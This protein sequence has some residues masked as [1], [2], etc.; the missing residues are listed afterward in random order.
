MELVTVTHEIHTFQTIDRPC[1]KLLECDF[2]SWRDCVEIESVIVILLL[3]F[4]IGKLS[5]FVV[6]VCAALGVYSGVIV[7]DH[8][9]CC[10]CCLEASGVA[11]ADVLQQLQG[12]RVA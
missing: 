9:C 5:S 3:K 1:L 8:G 7:S 4:C 6:E 2:C 12:G 11:I 10:V